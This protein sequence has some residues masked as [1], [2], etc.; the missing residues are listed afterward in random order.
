[1]VV[2]LNAGNDALPSV[3]LDLR[4]PPDVPLENFLYFLRGLGL[5]LRADLNFKQNFSNPGSRYDLTG[6]FSGGSSFRDSKSWGLSGDM[7]ITPISLDV[8]YKFQSTGM[9]QPYVNAGVSYFMGNVNLESTMGL[10][11]AYLIYID[12]DW[13]Q[14]VEYLNVPLEKIDPGAGAQDAG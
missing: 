1:V 11:F 7:S 5:R 4:V 3:E 2:L 14:K 12:P 6:E 8:I 9:F 13:W 10:S